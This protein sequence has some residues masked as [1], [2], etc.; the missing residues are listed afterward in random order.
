MITLIDKSNPNNSFK[1][2]SDYVPIDIIECCCIVVDDYGGIG[3]SGVW[4]GGVDAVVV[5]HLAGNTA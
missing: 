3:C 1:P 4:E 5:V 2:V